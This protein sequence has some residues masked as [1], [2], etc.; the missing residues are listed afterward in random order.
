MLSQNQQEVWDNS[1][2]SL[3]MPQTEAQGEPARYHQRPNTHLQ[4]FRYS[5][6]A[7][8]AR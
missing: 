2:T 6:G 1:D 8:A 3:G 7:G 4:E 5:Q